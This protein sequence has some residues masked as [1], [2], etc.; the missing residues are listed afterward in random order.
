[1]AEIKIRPVKS[2]KPGPDQL[3]TESSSRTNAICPRG[4]PPKVDFSPL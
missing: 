4:S 1:M 3:L 2:I